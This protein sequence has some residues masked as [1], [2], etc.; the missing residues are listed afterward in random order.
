MNKLVHK[1]GKRKTAIA[2]TTINEG[3]G[4]IRINS[5]PLDLYEPEIAKLKIKEPV[6]LAEEHGVDLNSVDISIKSYGGGVMGQ[7]DAIATSV[8]RA[9]ADY[10]G[11]DL[12]R[13]Y[14]DYNRIMI[15]GDHRQ[16]EPHKPGQSS[17]GP[18]HRRQKS[19]R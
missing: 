5:I 15:A 18:R 8:A 17:K 10:A 11:E 7:A 12:L 13:V 16:T 6:A 2:R 1:P 4:N 14:M 19:Y 3:S 9:L